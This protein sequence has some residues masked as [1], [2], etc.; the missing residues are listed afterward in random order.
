MDSQ[1]RAEK[2]SI[3]A[4]N[5]HPLIVMIPGMLLTAGPDGLQRVVVMAARQE[6]GKKRSPP[7]WILGENLLGK[8]I[9]SSVWGAW[10]RFSS[11]WTF[12]GPAMKREGSPAL[13]G[14][15]LPA[16][17]RGRPCYWYRLKRWNALCW[18]PGGRTGKHPRAWF[19][20]VGK[21]LSHVLLFAT[22]PA[23]TRQASLSFTVSWSLL[24]FMSIESVMLSNHL[25][26]C[27]PLLLLPSTF[28]FLN[29]WFVPGLSCGI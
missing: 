18:V 21:S 5:W 6:P 20:L 8:A 26:F 3:A 2:E 11:C 1:C 17:P 7:A 24:K 27:H 14:D 4:E 12:L 9:S 10:D 13:Q 19:V 23:F 29:Y 25:I 16:E 28:S 15:S 22:P